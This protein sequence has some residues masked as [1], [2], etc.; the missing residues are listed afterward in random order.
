MWPSNNLENKTLLNP[1]WRVQLVRN[2][3]QSHISLKP[4]LEYNHKQTPEVE[5]TKEWYQSLTLRN[6]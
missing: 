2:E 4:P 3:V 6:I 1:S 5:Q